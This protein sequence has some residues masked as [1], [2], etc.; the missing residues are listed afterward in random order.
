MQDKIN[1]EQKE[2][3]RLLKEIGNDVPKQLYYKGIWDPKLF[4]KC[5]AVVG[6]RQMTSY[7]KRVVEQIVGDVAQAGIT[8]VS[9]F[10]YGVDAAAHEAAVRS[11]GR[12]I[13]VMPCGIDRVHPA[14]QKKLYA[15]IIDHEGLI[16][17]EFS[18]TMLPSNWT[19]PKRNRIVAGLSQAVLVVEAGVKS[20][21]LIT[22]GYA[23]KYNRKL[24]AVPGPITNELS[25][26]TNRLLQHGAELASSA[27]EILDFFGVPALS[28]VEG[29]ARSAI[30]EG[31]ELN[32]AK[33][34]RRE[35]LEID[36]LARNLGVPVAEL[37]TA[38]SL[39]QLRGAV[40]LERGKYYLC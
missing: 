12:T 7:G 8:I 2:Y 34:L 15:D 38:L 40:S 22:A 14:H 9:G 10:M 32:I 36:V 37:G 5:L 25:Q 21:S 24:F 28:E 27:K 16:L 30:P 18:G 11:G 13:A 26:G 31:L 29:S 1:I 20:G 39:L 19:Y 4:D 3:P 17:S 35:S 33:E 6:A 23:K